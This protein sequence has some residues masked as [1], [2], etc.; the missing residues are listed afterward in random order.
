MNPV[1]FG[2]IGDGQSH[3]LCERFDTLHAAQQVYPRALSLDEEL[4]R[5]ALQAMIDNA[6]NIGSSVDLSH[7]AFVLDWPLVV[8][9]PLGVV[10]GNK[11]TRL[12]VPTAFVPALIMI[13]KESN[14]APV[15]PDGL[16]YGTAGWLS[17]GA[18]LAANFKQTPALTVDLT[19]TLP[20]PFPAGEWTLAASSGSLNNQETNTAFQLTVLDTGEVRFTVNTTVGSVR[21]A[22]APMS[23]PLRESF[24]LVAQYNG[25]RVQVWRVTTAGVKLIVDGSHSGMVIQKPW[26]DVIFGYLPSRWP[27]GAGAT[28]P[29]PGTIYRAIQFKCFATFSTNS[30][31]SG[32]VTPDD[33]LGWFTDFSRVD[34][35]LIRAYI[36]GNIQGALLW[37]TGQYLG[38]RTTFVE[39]LRIEG[40]THGLVVLNSNNGAVRDVTV[41]NHRVY[42][43]FFQSQN[44][45]N[46]IECC[47]VFGGRAGIC[48]ANNSSIV[49]V[50]D[51][52]VEGCQFGLIFSDSAGA[53]DGG[54]VDNCSIAN[55]LVKGDN[56][57]VTATAIAFGHEGSVAPYNVLLC[58]ALTFAFT[59]CQF[60]SLGMAVPVVE[61]Q[62]CHGGTFMGCLFGV[63]NTAPALIRLVSHDENN[64]PIVEGMGRWSGC[65]G[66]PLFDSDSA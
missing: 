41:F 59:G 60:T 63:A 3:P 7:G 44:Y 23:V 55:L 39:G 5:H 11:R 6:L 54:W 33:T 66:V 22:S 24:R 20:N 49:T 18:D 29:P 10:R 37:R 34:G 32:V 26:E 46:L 45:G 17:F 25:E 13:P 31:P 48:L 53:I 21:Y 62:R 61:L 50:R 27:E 8:T 38:T 64:P 12:L 42:G 47:Q 43:I 9:D 14:V 30:P 58:D 1:Y 28:T 56:A 65:E 36:N 52:H 51:C 19:L 40:G 15:G 2:A 16:T 35:A 4:D 57:T